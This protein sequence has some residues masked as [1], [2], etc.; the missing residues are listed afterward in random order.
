LNRDDRNLELDAI[1]SR[2]IAQ[3]PGPATPEC[4]DPEM[5]AAYYDRSLAEADR[6]R[7]EAHLADCARCQA[8]L[9]A[10]ARADEAAAR[11]R[12]RHGVS[13]LR[14]LIVVPALAAAAA[15]LLVVRTMRTSNDE[16]RRTDQIAMAKHQA[17][18]TELAARAPASS[19]AA[20]SAPSAPAS[21]ELAL[22]EAKPAP[23]PR[24]EMREQTK[25]LAKEPQLPKSSE[26]IG[27]A[28]SREASG[29]LARTESAPA[30]AR[31]PVPAP[32]QESSEGMVAAP[33]REAPAAA[34][35]PY[36]MS[37]T[38]M[39]PRPRAD[40]SSLAAQSSGAS[41]QSGAAPVGGAAMAGAEI[42][43]SVD[44]SQLSEQATRPSAGAAYS[45]AKGAIAGSPMPNSA[46]APEMLA[47]ISP[48]NQSAS[49]QVGRN[50]TILRRDADGSTRPQ[51]SGVS[52]DLTAGAAPSATV[53]WIVGRSG[54]IIRTIDGEHWLLIASPTGD[55]LVAVASD[56][57]DHALVTTASGQN[58]ATSDGGKSWHRQ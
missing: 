34:P 31:P 3:S 50:G 48:P 53:C 52:T 35:A 39:A 9:A 41:E 2:A 32:A 13:W 58:F 12:S 27:K 29:A 8:Q 14:P 21:N 56:S 19:P 33:S 25:S 11:A 28:P 30:F 49:W 55:N 7:L 46:A 44:R 38:A 57:A 17:P 40:V 37:D 42:G 6:D 4:A 47:L 45:S 54:T 18:L 1:L 26:V 15:L 20:A 16:S 51:H 22:N 23:E 24:D 10:M 43:A 36:A 5:L